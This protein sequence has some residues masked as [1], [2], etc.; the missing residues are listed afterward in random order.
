MHRYFALSI[1]LV[2]LAFASSAQAQIYAESDSNDDVQV[3]Y[4]SSTT[5]TTTAIGVAMIAASVVTLVPDEESA[6]MERYLRDNAVAVQS[7]ISLGAGEALHDIATI[8][9]LPEASRAEFGKV[10]RTHR[11]ELLGLARRDTLTRQRTAQFVAIVREAW[12]T[13]EAAETTSS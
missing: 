1:A 9:K 6:Y 4:F 10:L 3:L 13:H 12:A 7:G 5:T 2:I 8:L 11:K